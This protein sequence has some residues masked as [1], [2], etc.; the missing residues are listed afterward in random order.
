MVRATGDVNWYRFTVQ[1]HKTITMALYGTFEGTPPI[2]TLR[3][4]KGR[5]IT[6][7]TAVDPLPGRNG[8][9]VL[10]QACLGAT[11]C[12]GTYYAAVR[13]DEITRPV[14]YELELQVY[15]NVEPTPCP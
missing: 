11:I 2:V 5:Y 1:K 6:D 9:C 14:G 10:G 13:D 8:N 3:D 15:I 7:N 4:A 12:P